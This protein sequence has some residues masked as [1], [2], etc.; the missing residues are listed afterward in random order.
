MEIFYDRRNKRIIM[1]TLKSIAT[2]R[3]VA[4]FKMIERRPTLT[5]FDV[6][7]S[8]ELFHLYES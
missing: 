8:F 3:L 2:E 6:V 4:P 5:K 7:N 1:G